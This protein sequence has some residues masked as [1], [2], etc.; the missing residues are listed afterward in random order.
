MLECT[1]S[2]EKCGGLCTGWDGKHIWAERKKVNNKIECES[3]RDEANKLET[4]THDLVNVR[5]GKTVFD[6]N[7][8]NKF[9]GIVTCANNSC[10]KEGKC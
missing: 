7:N 6:K 2:Q 10:K 1:I 9:V 4:F 5:L 3:C 8:W